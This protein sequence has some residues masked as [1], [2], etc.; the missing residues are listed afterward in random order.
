MRKF[1]IGFFIGC[2]FWTGISWAGIIDWAQRSATNQHLS[3][4]I[5]IGNKQIEILT[6]I[7]EVN[8]QILIIKKTGG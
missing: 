7:L 8:K 1:L 4:Q 5:S 2:V 6:E 3:D